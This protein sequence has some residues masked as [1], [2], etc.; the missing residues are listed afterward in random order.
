MPRV[1]AVVYSMLV[2]SV[3]CIAPSSWEAWMF[4]SGLFQ[5]TPSHPEGSERERERQERQR[6]RGREGERDRQTDRGRAKGVHVSAPLFERIFQTGLSPSQS[7]QQKHALP[8]H[9]PRQ[10]QAVLVRDHQ[11]GLLGL[12][13]GLLGF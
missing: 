1:A 6:G 7:E 12:S 5:I 4:N 2:S 8:P 9:R 11:L 3:V 13:L 10:I